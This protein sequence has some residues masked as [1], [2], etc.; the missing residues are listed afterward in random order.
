[1]QRHCARDKQGPIG[2]GLHDTVSRHHAALLEVGSRC[3]D[4]DSRHTSAL[5]EQCDR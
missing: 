4:I 3:Y 2:T 1:M 5:T